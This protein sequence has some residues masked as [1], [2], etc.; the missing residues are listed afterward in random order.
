[1]AKVEIGKLKERILELAE[2]SYVDGKTREVVKIMA[3]RV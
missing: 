3:E 1:M 2:E